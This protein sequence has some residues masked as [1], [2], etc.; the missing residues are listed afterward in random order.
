MAWSGGTYRKGNYGTNGWTGDASLGIGIEAGRHDTQDD[1]FATGINACLAKDGSNSATGNLNAG[2]FK[3][4]NL[5]AGTALTDA[6][7]LSQVQNRTSAY[8][9]TTGGTST[10]FTVT[11]TPTITSLV[12]GASYFFKANAANGAAATLKID[13]TAATTMQRQ[14]TALVGNEF[15]ANDLIE[16]VYDGTNFQIVNIASAPLYLDRTNNK[17]GIGTTAP[18]TNLDIAT[19]STTVGEVGE[20]IVAY[21]T[22]GGKPAEINLCKSNNATV[23]TNTIISNGQYCGAIRFWGANGTGFDPAAIIGGFIDG[24]PGASGD[25]PG[26]LN[27][28]TTADG[29]AS[30]T[31]RMRITNDGIVRLN[32][33]GITEINRANA[34]SATSS[35][36]HRLQIDGTTHVTLGASASET[37]SIYTGVGTMTERIR[38]ASNNFAAFGMAN[39][40]GNATMKYNTSTGAWTYDTSSLRFKENIR[41]SKYGLDHILALNPRQYNYKS[42]KIEDVGFIAEE[43]IDVIPELAPLDGEGKPISV[44]YDRLTSVLCKAIQELNAKVEAL[45]ARVA[46]LEA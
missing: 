39:A 20:R 4:T 29:S 12:T 27:F 10:A 16:V 42:D 6:A 5:G 21:S 22:D 35:G 8:L 1:D 15:K 34:S 41:P 23:G 13:G 28:F 14:G 45:E 32:T 30:P 9:G 44:S 7:T 19:G 2:S 37:C 24:T 40:V 46:A 36:C 25:M 17:V 3:V 38:F 31:E 11:A 33:G 18:T 26:G 43:L